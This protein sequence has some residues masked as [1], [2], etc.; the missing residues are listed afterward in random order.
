MADQPAHTGLIWRERP[1][2]G[3]PTAERPTSPA[4]DRADAVYA[5]LRRAII[6]QSLMPGDKLPEDTIGE[7]FG[8]S[9]TLVRGALTRLV[10]D[11]LVEQWKNRGSFVASP[12]LVEAQQVFDVRRQPEG[13]VVERLAGALAREHANRLHGHVA[14]EKRF[15]GKEGPEA[16]RLAGEFHVL[17]AELTGN[18]LLARYVSEVVSRS[19]L[20]LALYSRPHPSE[21]GASEHAE[22]IEAL[23]AGNAARARYLMDHHLGAVQERALLP[24]P[25]AAGRSLKDVLVR[26]AE[27]REPLPMASPTQRRA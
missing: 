9:R 22:I 23:I 12:S 6:E 17:L 4:A 21:C 14:A 18:T 26:Y 19:S 3:R 7:S 1:G 11:G 8:V 10:A 16:I 25:G 2:R 27:P 24:K 15:H 20:I 13:L 5:D